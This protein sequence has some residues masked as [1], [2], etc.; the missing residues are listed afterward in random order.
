M[1]DEVDWGAI[2]SRMMEAYSVRD[3][4]ATWTRIGLGFH[5]MGEAADAATSSFVALGGGRTSYT[6]DEFADQMREAEIA[7]RTEGINLGFK[8]AIDQ[9]VE[10]LA[11]LAQEHGYIDPNSERVWTS[12]GA[13]KPLVEEGDPNDGA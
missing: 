6:D 8:D 13:L 3:A 10:L 1:G 12:L 11:D 2:E 5:G 4:A 7:G 9:V